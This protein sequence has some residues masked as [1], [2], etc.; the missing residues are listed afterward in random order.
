MS[1]FELN[2]IPD[3]YCTL[4]VPKYITLMFRKDI[5]QCFIDQLYVVKNF[6]KMLKP[7]K[8]DSP[9]TSS[10]FDFGEV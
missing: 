1:A 9:T 7:I 2:N 4:T 3:R 6:P 5:G 10:I 8:T